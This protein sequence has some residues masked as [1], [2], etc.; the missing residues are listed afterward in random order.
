M[1]LLNLQS[2]FVPNILNSSPAL[3][4]KY[5]PQNNKLLYPFIWTDTSHS[6]KN[7]KGIFVL[8]HNVNVPHDFHNSL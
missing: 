6:L 2:E 4:V 7:N 1:T 3:W 8:V 5:D